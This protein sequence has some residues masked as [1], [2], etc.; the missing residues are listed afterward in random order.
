MLF[1]IVS[2]YQ[3]KNRQKLR[4]QYKEQDSNPLVCYPSKCYL[5]KIYDESNF[6]RNVQQNC[7]PYKNRY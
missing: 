6:K 2:D 1:W 4:V 5:N 3:K 7:Y